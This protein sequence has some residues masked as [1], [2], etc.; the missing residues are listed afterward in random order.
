MLSTKRQIGVE[1]RSGPELGTV[2]LKF[3]VVD[4]EREL[5]KNDH[6]LFSHYAGRAF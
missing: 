6:G 2:D 1:I 4:M 3:R 5:S